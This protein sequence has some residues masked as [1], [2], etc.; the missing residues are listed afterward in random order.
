MSRSSYRTLPVFLLTAGIGVAVYACKPESPT[1]PDDNR[2]PNAS[3]I[4]PSNNSEFELGESIS[5]EGGASDPEDGFLTGTSLVWTSSFDGQI[6]TG[7]AFSRSDLS[8]GTH[9]IRLIATDTDGAADTVT[10]SIGVGGV[11]N[12]DPTASFSFS[13]SNPSRS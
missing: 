6:G 7:I 1:G 11:P 2:P 5:F 4:S 8:A 3:I 12:R 9:T 10:I 13:C